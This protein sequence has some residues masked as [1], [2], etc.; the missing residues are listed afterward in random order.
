[1]GSTSD[2]ALNQVRSSERRVRE[3][4]CFY[5]HATVFTHTL[6]RDRQREIRY[7]SEYEYHAV[8]SFRRIWWDNRLAVAV[9]RRYVK[10]CAGWILADRSQRHGT[11]I[12]QIH[13]GPRSVP[14]W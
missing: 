14:R 9:R 5:K 1:M 2:S 10:T 12:P 13:G 11:S 8:R 4:K 3:R 6:R 7:H